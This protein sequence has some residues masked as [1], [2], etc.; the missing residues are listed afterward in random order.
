M[1]NLLR[2]SEDFYLLT[3]NQT[4]GRRG[5]N[6]LIHWLQTLGT[7]ETNMLSSFSLSRQCHSHC[8]CTHGGTGLYTAVD[9]VPFPN[10]KYVGKY[11]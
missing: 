11:D 2:D 1:E 9:T 5:L 8:E 6:N 3:A 7:L 10:I 4:V